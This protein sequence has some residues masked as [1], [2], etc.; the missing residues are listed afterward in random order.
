[1]IYKE[2]VNILIDTLSRFKGVNFVKYQGDD[3][4][5]QQHNYN[6]IQCYIDDISHHQF[7]IT[8]NTAK[9]EFNVYILGF[10]EENT[11]EAILNIQDKCYEVALYT[12][13]YIDNLDAY[14]GIVSL[15]DYDI[16]TLS[17]YTAQSNAGVRLS[18]IL[19][20][21]NGVNMCELDEHFGEPYEPQEDNEITID[22]EDVGD[23]DLKPIRLKK[24]RVC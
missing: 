15:Y 16:M 10:P 13:A 18:I 8:Q 21:P 22:K 11:P 20:I 4:N 3:L 5:N 19:T 2:V 24:N 17:R 23:I 9:V 14:K 12:L 6:T 1:M 7:N